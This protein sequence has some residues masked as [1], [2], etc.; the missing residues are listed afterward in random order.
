MSNTTSINESAYGGTVDSY[1][2][3]YGIPTDVFR[4]VIRQLSNFDPT[5]VN[6]KGGSGISNLQTTAKTVDP[7]NVDAS[8]NFTASYLSSLYKSIGTWN[9]ATDSYLGTGS[10]SSDPS[11]QSANEEPQFDAMGNATGFKNGDSLPIKDNGGFVGNT[12]S[13]VTTFLKESAY[14]I[15]FV[16]VGALLIAASLWVLIENSGKK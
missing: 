8:L 12:I 3:R 6:P 11:G 13:S 1:A 16:L 14:T 9:G 5:Q 2:V 7:M 15:L 10:A 4:D